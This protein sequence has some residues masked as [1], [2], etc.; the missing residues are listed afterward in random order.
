ML[1]LVLLTA[2]VLTSVT[3]KVKITRY[4]EDRISQKLE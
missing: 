1:G 3:V 4:Q 2:L